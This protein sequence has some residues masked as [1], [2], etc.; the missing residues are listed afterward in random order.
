MN[1]EKKIL[2][3]LEKQYTLFKVE[4]RKPKADFEDCWSVKVTTR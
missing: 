1:K 3:D 4:L 2:R